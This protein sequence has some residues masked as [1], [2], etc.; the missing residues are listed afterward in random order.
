[1]S[2]ANVDK[3]GMHET[4]SEADFMYNNKANGN[5]SSMISNQKLAQMLSPI[6]PGP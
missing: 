5:N 4:N 6:H 3:S 1:M 2:D